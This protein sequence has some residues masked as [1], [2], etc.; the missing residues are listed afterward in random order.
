VTCINFGMRTRARRWA[1]GSPIGDRA[2][3]RAA[4]NAPDDDEE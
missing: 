4:A 3:R 1:C 2:A